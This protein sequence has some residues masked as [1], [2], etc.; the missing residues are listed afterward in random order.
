M[1]RT[2][3]ISLFL[4]LAVAVPA[5]AQTPV[6]LV[7]PVADAAALADPVQVEAARRIV[8]TLQLAAQEYRLAWQGGALVNT[9]EW[10]E[11]RLF[12]A[13]A[14]RAVPQL[15]A[16]LST[17]LEGRLAALERRVAGRMPAE[18][19]AIEARAIETRL[20]AAL[21]TSLDE[22]PAR[23]PSLAEGA[24]LYASSC[25]SCHGAGGHG[26]GVAAAGMDPPPADLTAPATLASTTPLDYYRKITHGVPGTAMQSFGSLTKEE[27]WDIV[28]HVFALSDTAARGGRGGQLA[29]VFG[30]VRGTLGA[31]MALAAQGDAPAAGQK[32][33]D[34]YMAFE[35]V[36]ASLGAT[37]PAIVA[38][39]EER[40]TALRTAAVTGQP[41]PVLEARRAE[42]LAALAE[43]EHALTRGR[44]PIG[45]FV[46]S[47]LLMLRE[48]FEA[49]LVVGAIMAV[50]LKA[51]AEHRRATVRWGVGAALLASLLT[52][53]ALEW[54]FRATPAQ[55]EALEGG[56]MLLAAATLFYVS[57][58][59]VSKIEI[60]AWTRFVK[61][62]IQKAVE[63]GSA[64]SLAAV[65]FLAVY[66]E[67]FET[68]LFYKALFVTGGAG[69]GAPIT[70]G[71]V[72]GL[73]VLA[74]VYVG[75]ERFGIRIPMRPFFAVTGATLAYMAFVFAGRGV[76]ELQ[77]GGYVPS[78]LV[79]GGPRNDFL[80]IF[81][82]VESLAV[83]GLI[84]AAILSALVWTFVVQPR[85]LARL[86]PVHA[87][88]PPSMDRPAGRKPRPDRE[89][90]QA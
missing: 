78:T 86:G 26:D 89:A 19:L 17:E 77:E 84:L 73:V 46:E 11:A 24:R 80:G 76:K 74:A 33:F 23:E 54:V 72:V 55:R 38:R 59:L 45:L 75:I 47:L 66:R 60:A 6:A 68:V 41:V 70:G 64:V 25:A 1:N 88:A 35:A 30:T 31:A 9:A 83:Q 81:P 16:A 49:I 69:A 20:T 53:A 15:G 32:V 13:E 18:S 5:V 61:G 82:T 79:P 58:W 62:H 87:S 51:G 42:L 71:M 52:A 22:R 3:Y 85:R 50:L 10:E 27:R 63:S 8:A 28:A 43:A 12:I 40:F 29:V 90:A 2:P 14:R 56:V 34:A 48:G 4:S 57:Y 21:G 7:R 37:D 65:A 67:G 36:E 44:S 39:T